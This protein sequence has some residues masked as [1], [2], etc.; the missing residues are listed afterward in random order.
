MS[1]L[2]K[3]PFKKI[4]SSTSRSLT[5]V[6]RAVYTCLKSSL[7]KMLKEHFWMK[8]T[9]YQISVHCLLCSKGG[10][11][12][13]K[14]KD[15]ANECRK[16]KCLHHFT[17]DELVKRTTPPRCKFAPDRRKTTVPWKEY[18]P[19]FEALGNIVHR[20]ETQKTVSDPNILEYFFTSFKAVGHCI[21]TCYIL[22]AIVGL[23]NPVYFVMSLRLFSVVSI[24]FCKLLE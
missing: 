24:S 15:H 6:C 19:W 5:D 22:Y 4:S 16:D 7:G 11:T 12:A 21:K 18:T 8:S 20:K 10:V 14:C 23:V 2:A 9:N 3:V 1:K 17:E 13:N